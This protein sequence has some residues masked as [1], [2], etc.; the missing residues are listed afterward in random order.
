MFIKFLTAI[1]I[2]FIF[3]TPA[4]SLSISF[5]YGGQ[6][7]YSKNVAAAG[8]PREYHLE[9]PLGNSSFGRL[10][11]INFN[12]FGQLNGIRLSYEK[13]ILGK[14]DDSVYSLRLGVFY[15]CYWGNPV[16]AIKNDYVDQLPDSY[17]EV[18]ISLR[19][20]IFRY[21]DYFATLLD[22]YVGIDPLNRT[23][24]NYGVSFFTL[25]CLL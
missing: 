2:I 10:S 1:L 15:T 8:Y 7:F 13:A 21:G 18:G 3:I 11:Y 9:M 5:G 6:Y 16:L 12:Y 14:E 4:Y 23:K 25:G 24:I 22:T 20:A 19:P 17:H